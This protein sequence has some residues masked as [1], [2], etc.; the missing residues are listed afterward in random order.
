MMGVHHGQVK[1]D[2][3]RPVPCPRCYS[4]LCGKLDASWT[5]ELGISGAPSCTPPP[6]PRDKAEEKQ[7]KKRTGLRHVPAFYVSINVERL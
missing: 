7:K 5:P 2:K 1:D 3:A 4:C 6:R